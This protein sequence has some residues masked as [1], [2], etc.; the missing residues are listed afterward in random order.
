MLSSDFSHTGL[1]SLLTL[2]FVLQSTISANR[3]L[4]G[5]TILSSSVEAIEVLTFPVA[6]FFKNRVVG[7]N[8]EAG[9]L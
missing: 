6:Q 8:V 2:Q 3:Y 7:R 1:Y 5:T 9:H 4:I